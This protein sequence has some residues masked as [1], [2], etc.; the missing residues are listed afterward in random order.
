[1]KLG[2]DVTKRD[3]S[4]RTALDH[5]ASKGSLELFN[6]LIERGAS[7]RAGKMVC[8]VEGGN[9]EILKLLLAAKA[10]LN[11]LQWG[12]SPLSQAVISGRKDVVKLLIDAGANLEQTDEDPSGR[13]PLLSAVA[14][15]H[16]E[17]VK[18]LASSGA[19]VN[20]INKF[21]EESPLDVA[22]SPPP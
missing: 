15:G 18:L 2:A 21:T 10:D 6:F 20:V 19:N 1:L 13:T 17:I 11:V 16:L 22:K 14:L 12:R 5:A 8:A 3:K 9:F 4:Q 7:V